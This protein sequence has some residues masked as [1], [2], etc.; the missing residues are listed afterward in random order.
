[1]SARTLALATFAA[2]SLTYLAAADAGTGL[3]AELMLGVN[4]EAEADQISCRSGCTGTQALSDED[5]EKNLGV[6]ATYE[7]AVKPR[8][9]VGGR[10]SY[11]TGQGDDTDQDLAMLNVGGWARYLIPAGPATVH[12][13]ADLGPT[14]A[15]SEVAVAGIAMDFSGLGYHVVAGGG[16]SAPLG[17][18]VEFRGGLYYSY[19]SVGSLEA[20]ESFNGQAVEVEIEDLVA[21]R[22]LV[23]AGIAF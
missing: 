20:D 2:T 7:R 15:T 11:V 3:E 19:E 16:V 14:Y 10:A 21:T 12:V 23:T 17:G 6:A 5:L 22:V 4:G 13:G 1:M 18:G 9:R 8:L